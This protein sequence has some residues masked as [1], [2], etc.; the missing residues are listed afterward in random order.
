MAF[1][2]LLMQEQSKILQA[3]QDKNDIDLY[4]L[5]AEASKCNLFA[6]LE[7]IAEELEMDYLFRLD[8]DT[9][10]EKGN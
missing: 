5:F 1:T 8:D 9:K 10:I 2:F 6:G 7:V 3:L 4:E